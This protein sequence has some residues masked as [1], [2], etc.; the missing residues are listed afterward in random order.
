MPKLP[1]DV[2]YTIEYD[3]PQAASN[4]DEG[5]WARRP[6]AMKASFE[7][8]RLAHGHHMYLPDEDS[9]AIA[10]KLVKTCE[11][12]EAARARY[13]GLLEAL[14]S[15]QP[16]LRELADDAEVSCMP[17]QYSSLAMQSEW[18]ALS[19][20]ARSSADH[21]VYLYCN[22]MVFVGK[23]VWRAPIPDTA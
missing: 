10:V 8:R 17:F 9:S 6:C 16:L 2:D 5:P 12:H 21:Q 23:S 20:L 11:K 14:Q 7:A 15:L 18:S 19:V 22:G 1:Y 4:E 13:K 3:P